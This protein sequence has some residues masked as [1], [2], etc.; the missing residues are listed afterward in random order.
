MDQETHPFQAEVSR[1]LGIVTHSLYTNREIFLRELI[2]NASDACD[3]LRHLAQTSPE[4]GPGE[5]EL[6][7]VLEPDPAASTLTIADNG[8]GM[9][10]DELIAN[11]GTIARSGT[12]K[13]MEELAGDA[14]RDLPL[15]GQFGVGFYSAFMVADR[16]SVVS[17]RAG[18]AGAWRWDS[19]GAGSF[20]TAPAAHD[21]ARGTRVTLH[22]KDDAQEFLEPHRLQE[23]V[24]SYSDHVA[25]P[26][27]LKSAGKEEQINAGR[28][29]WTRP[30]SAIT[31]RQY[32]EFYRHAAHA[33]DEPW[34]VLHNRAEGVISYA[35]LLF[36]P[37]ARPHDLF[38]P[39]RKHG[40]K[41]YVRRVFVT[42]HCDDL[43]PGWLR[44][45]R[46]VVDSEDL[47][48][49]ISRET[50][51]KNPIL[52]KM[53]SGL[54]KRILG[55]L[56][57]KAEAAPE[58]YA[59]FWENFGGAIKEGLY[60][61]SNERDALLGLVRF[62]S[63]GAEGWV[64]LAD[65][66]ARMKPGQSL[67]YTAAGDD[68][69]ALKASPQLEGFRARGLEVLLL[70]DAVDEF[71][72]AMVGGYNGKNF[73][74]V[75][76]GE[77][78][79]SAFPLLDA[80]TKEAE[81]PAKGIHSLVALLKLALTDKVKDVRESDRLTDSAVCLVADARDADLHLERLL[82]QHKRIETR[83][84]RILEINPRHPLIRS[85]AAR[86][87]DQGPDLK[88]DDLAL[89]LLDQAQILEGEPLADPAG[90][91][92]RLASIM[93]KGVGA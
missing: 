87:S 39:E 66:V 60:E 38:Q 77:S 75:T 26:V 51:Q 65:Y 78:D 54:V 83:A 82:R 22:L 84:A 76:Q 29:L 45:M 59:K 79:L 14:R 56:K 40:V 37:G 6:R 36:I 48:L 20:T 70:T 31:E 32:A 74:S 41:L 30:K 35:S 19:D 73:R 4:T 46:G 2:S 7:I 12:A 90:F 11:L 17:R 44:F 28:A 43:L 57:T 47:P 72:P 64:S 86:V 91:A 55:E 68:P 63:T 52:A 27:M 3:R 62:R 89:L 34:M 93:Q 13:F 85:L 24:R 61:E 21:S 16:V 69:D 33:F 80:A 81:P 10:R 50:L 5:E 58:D 18:E 23:I 49:N 53:R 8:V 9:N 71:W 15:I 88:M 1:L 92:R 25:L 42:D 67:I